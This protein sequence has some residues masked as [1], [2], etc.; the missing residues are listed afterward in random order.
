MKSTLQ[1]YECALSYKLKSTTRPTQIN[2]HSLKQFFSL[3]LSESHEQVTLRNIQSKMNKS[4]KP[5]L[6]IH[7]S[8]LK[9][10]FQFHSFS[11]LSPTHPVPVKHTLNADDTTQWG[12]THT[13][14][15]VSSEATRTETLNSMTTR[16][17]SQSTA[18]NG[19]LRGTLHI[20]ARCKSP[21]NLDSGGD[22]WSLG[23]RNGRGDLKLINIL[24]M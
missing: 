8:Y 10:H 5:Q 13:C 11:F 16:T 9:N 22:K 18:Y 21:Q 3:S 12:H 14:R 20:T 4:I 15:D 6:H 19:E 23:N 17:G 1:S 2:A 24:A 7:I